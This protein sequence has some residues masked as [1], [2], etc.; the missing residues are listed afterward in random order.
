M[1][2][3]DK[4]GFKEIPHRFY[5]ISYPIEPILEQKHQEIIGLE[6]IQFVD[7]P[8][9]AFSY[10]NY[11]GPRSL[12][13]KI[14]EMIEL[15][16]EED[17]YILLST[18][19]LNSFEVIELIISAVKKLKGK[20]YILIGNS[21]L[22]SISFNRHGMLK[23]KNIFDLEAN[24]ALIRQNSGAHLK[25][26]I[27]GKRCMVFTTNLSSDGLFYNP[28]FGLNFEDEPWI[29]ACLK[30]IFKE[31]WHKRSERM[32]IN[33]EWLQ[34]KEW[35]IQNNSE[36]RIDNVRNPR[37]APLILSSNSLKNQVRKINP[38]INARTL[39]AYTIRQLSQATKSIDIAIFSFYPIPEINPIIELL[40]EKAKEGVSIKILVPEVQVKRSRDM[41]TL[42]DKLKQ[43]QIKVRYY[44]EIH[45]KAIIIDDNRAIIF[46]GNFN[47]YLLKEDSYDL[48]LF[49][50][51]PNLIQNL[52][53]FY[54]HL[55][56]EAADSPHEHPNINLNLNLII[57]SPN[58]IA[59]GKRVDISLL[60]KLIHQSK[61]IQLISKD[62]NYAIVINGAN[63]YSLNLP[64]EMIE[65]EEIDNIINMRAIIISKPNFRFKLGD[66]YKIRNLQ[67]KLLWSK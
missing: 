55:W 25:F 63:K 35:K 47:K 2:K 4:A 46:T 11:E 8:Y 58:F 59:D 52:T 3:S 19:Y 26:L 29:I 44:R 38:N 15:A 23:K 9:F 65:M 10:Y 49:T 6:K 37:F 14:Q 17:S 50:N 67:L 21:K 48:G 43:N 13:S 22:S 57:K 16:V 42:L 54:L 31:L 30:E 28:E 40:I 60:E 66:F 33:G 61:E 36:G 1:S 12:F 51:S 41:G 62:D 34:A 5:D 7:D 32:L 18:L 53:K 64:L 24:G 27:A 56:E 39:F 45:G 20:V